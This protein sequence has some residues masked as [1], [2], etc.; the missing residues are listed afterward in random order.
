M[1]TRGVF[2][3]SK[4]GSGRSS[5]DVLFARDGGISGG[6]YPF[7]E[8]VADVVG[9][10]FPVRGAFRNMRL[11]YAR[12][13]GVEARYDFI[14]SSSSAPGVDE[15]LPL[16]EGSDESPLWG[17]MGGRGTARTLKCGSSRTTCTWSK[18]AS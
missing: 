1:K 3:H 14:C 18:E 8:G 2:E 11:K 10:V 6:S 5:G 16:V 13:V 4:G 9:T 7:A 17:V 12:L 15:P